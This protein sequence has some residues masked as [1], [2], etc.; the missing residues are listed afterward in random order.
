[1]SRRSRRV[2]NCSYS[3]ANVWDLRDAVR[4]FNLEYPGVVNRIDKVLVSIGTNDVK[5]FDLTG[6]N[7]RTKFRQ[8]LV[9]LV[10]L[11]K[12]LLPSAQIIF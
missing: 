4:D 5:N 3:G 7:V 6:F 8:P 11:I 10:K 9:D 12:L 2:I 1:M